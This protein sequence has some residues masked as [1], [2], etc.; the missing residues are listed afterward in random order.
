MA[1]R[2]YEKNVGPGSHKPIS[3]S[4]GTPMHQALANHTRCSERTLRYFE[5]FV[6]F[7][8]RERDTDSLWELFEQQVAERPNTPAV[9]TP[10]GPVTYQQL[11]EKA[12]R[13]EAEVADFAIA[14]G[15][16][17]G[18]LIDSGEQMLAS[19]LGA[20]KASAPF[21]PIDP[22]V[23]PM[24]R[25][26]YVLDDADVRLVL[27]T[28]SH[29]EYSREAAGTVPV[30]CVED[31]AQTGSREKPARVRRESHGDIAWIIYTSGSTGEPKG[32]VQ[33]RRNVVH[34]ITT[35][36]DACGICPDDRMAVTFSSSVNFWFRETLSALCKGATIYP[37]NLPAGGF[38][39]LEQTLSRDQITL[40]ALVPSLFRRFVPSLSAPP[41]HL[42]LIKVG[43]EPV[44]RSDFELYREKLG[45]RC[46]FL[47][48]FGT[49]ETAPV[50]YHFLDH[51]S[52]VS[53]TYVPIGYPVTGSDIRIVDSDG[54]E[55]PRGETGEIVIRSPFLALQYWK[56]PRITGTTFREDPEDPSE[57]LYFTGD[58]G[59][60]R[61]D[62]CVVHLG[63]KDN[64]VQIH[65]YRVELAEIE[66]RLRSHPNVA[67]A[68]AAARTD[69]TGETRLTGY[70]VAHSQAPTISALKA[71]VLE[72]LPGYMLP[73]EW[74]FLEE[75]PKTPNGKLYRKA[76]PIPTDPRSNDPS[77][78][79]PMPTSS[80]EVT[81]AKHWRRAIPNVERISVQ[82]RFFDLGGDSLGAM[83]TIVAIEAEVGVEI[84]PLDMGRQSLGQLAR[85]CE[86]RQ[87]R[88]RESPR[89]ILA[90]FRQLKDRWAPATSQPSTRIKDEL[91]RE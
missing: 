57:R 25:A 2:S 29:L 32:V 37:I 36:A 43:G 62:G 72:S 64:Q 88:A 86:D 66:M 61:P 33:S 47:N 16:C 24:A 19:V 44:L 90:R 18:I 52:H 67:E 14:G 51:D 46:I 84:S 76:L 31:L 59:L 48:R 73:Q 50:R 39:E 17:I 45:K 38:R 70:V 15:G 74:L 21:V 26:K 68:A 78:D 54:E 20:L 55:A 4:A 6:P 28:R 89:G 83:Q 11:S 75:L 30:S 85:Y 42:R 5:S 12:Q 8:D 77:S 69:N 10:S 81:I 9:H 49:T 71:H 91:D 56:R 7:S 34:F 1:L 87:N 63:R 79:V 23:V 27:T 35:E 60:K 40:L 13:V 58:L 65:G 41:P 22:T 80:M 82:D 3:G 53:E